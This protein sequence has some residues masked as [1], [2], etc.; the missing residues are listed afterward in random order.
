MPINR[1]SLRTLD[2]A[3]YEFK[4]H[5]I[6]CRTLYSTP[7]FLVIHFD[8]CSHIRARLLINANR[9]FAN[10]I[11]K[12]FGISDLLNIYITLSHILISCAGHAQCVLD[13]SL[14]N[15]LICN[16]KIVTTNVFAETYTE[17]HLL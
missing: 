11:M 7:A 13:H 6:L 9:N 4:C 1:L 12:N 14:Q 2:D 5:H 17:Q 10:L 8:I 3:P 15:Y 16:L